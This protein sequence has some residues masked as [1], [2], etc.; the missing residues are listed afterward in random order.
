[1]PRL[2]RDDTRLLI[3][4]LEASV[5]RVVPDGGPGVAD[6]RLESILARLEQRLAQ[7]D[8]NPEGEPYPVRRGRRARSERMAGEAG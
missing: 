5:G 7:A 4:H 6:D 3:S 1:M 8:Q 2:S